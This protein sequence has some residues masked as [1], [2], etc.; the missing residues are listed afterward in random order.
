M[1]ISSGIPPHPPTALAQLLEA[2][3]NSPAR[4]LQMRHDSRNMRARIGPGVDPDGLVRTI[5]PVTGWTWNSLREAWNDRCG[6]MV[7]VET[8]SVMGDLARLADKLSGR[9]RW[10]PSGGTARHQRGHV[11]GSAAP[12]G[13]RL[14][15]PEDCR[16]RIDTRRCGGPCELPCNLVARCLGHLAPPGGDHPPGLLQQALYGQGAFLSLADEALLLEVVPQRVGYWTLP[17]LL[18]LRSCIYHVR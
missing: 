16:Q 11:P 18:G 13:R 10:R 17:G 15:R 9:Y 4:T 14:P 5:T 2:F 7:S 3:P 8:R 6:T 1:G 12:P